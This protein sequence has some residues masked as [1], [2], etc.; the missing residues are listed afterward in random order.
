MLRKLLCLMMIAVLPASLLAADSGGAMLYAKGTA[1]LNGGTVPRSSAIF[2]GDLIQT[3][4]NSVAN[5]N[6]AG[7]NVVIV[8]DSLVKFEGSALSVEHGG[9]SVATSKKLSTHAGDV[10]IAPAS[11][12]WTQYEVVEKDGRVQ[13]MAR[14]GDVTVSDDTG[15]AT[16]SQGQ[17]TT[18]DESSQKAEKKKKAGA[19][20]AAGGSIL[21]SRTAMFVGIG[22]AGGLTGWVLSQGDV[23]VSPSAP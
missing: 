6:A 4:T 1:W 14:K 8:A 3:K 5:I 15:T 22:V 19:V 18:R 21:D 23:P 10:A 11:D 9:V 17:Q 7:S 2:P 12:A 20:P 16:L 13:I